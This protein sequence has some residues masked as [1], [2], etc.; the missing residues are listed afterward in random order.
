M[1][2]SLIF[3]CL[4]IDLVVFTGLG[5]EGVKYAIRDMLEA[6]ILVKNK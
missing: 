6:R 4:K 3:Y 5:R 1:Q 2:P